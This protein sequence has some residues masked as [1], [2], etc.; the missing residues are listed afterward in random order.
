MNVDE[1]DNRIDVDLAIRTAP[2]FGI[3]HGVAKENAYE[4]LNTVKKN[5]ERIATGYGLTRRQ[6]EQMRPAFQLSETSEN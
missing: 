1:Q 6:I 5:W 4:I 3:T 2:Q